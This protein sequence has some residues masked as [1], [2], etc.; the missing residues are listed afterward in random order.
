MQETLGYIDASEPKIV[1]N[2]HLLKVEDIKSEKDLDLNGATVEEPTEIENA[3]V[4]FQDGKKQIQVDD[5]QKVPFVCHFVKKIERKFCITVQVD[6][7][8]TAPNFIQLS[9]NFS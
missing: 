5:F 9:Q 6:K 3:N 1:D 4:L 2:E 8:E 7:Y